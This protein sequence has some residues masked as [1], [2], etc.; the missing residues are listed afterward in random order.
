[1]LLSLGQFLASGSMLRA[2]QGARQLL[3]LVYQF[4]IVFFFALSGGCR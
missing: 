1:M 2:L 3:K 4:H